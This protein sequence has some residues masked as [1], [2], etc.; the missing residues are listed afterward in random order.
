MPDDNIHSN[1]NIENIDPSELLPSV[2]NFADY[3][4]RQGLFIHTFQCLNC[5][6][7]FAVF[8]W[9]ADRHTVVNTACPECCR[10][11]QKTHWCADI[12]TTPGTA[13]GDGPEIFDFSPV[14]ESARIM[15]D[16]SIFT[17]LPEDGECGHAE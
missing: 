7:E 13:F 3:T 4:Q 6:L 17:G 16:S 1:T 8:S 9:W 11:T 15:P 12:R 10:I 5:S 14:G 2:R